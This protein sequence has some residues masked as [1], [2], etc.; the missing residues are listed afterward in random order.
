MS[1]VDTAWVLVCSALVLLMTP[2]VAFFLR[3]VGT[4]EKYS[5]DFDV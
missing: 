2:G 3:R 4:S 1:G 5:F